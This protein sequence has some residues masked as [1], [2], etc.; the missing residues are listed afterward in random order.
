MLDVVLLFTGR[1]GTEPALSRLA[2]GVCV[3]GRVVTVTGTPIAKI[4]GDPES[5][6]QLFW[7]RCTTKYHRETFTR[8]V[9]RSRLP[10][11]SIR[12][13][14]FRQRDRAFPA[15]R[16]AVRGGAFGS[17]A[18]RFAIHSEE[19]RQ[20]SLLPSIFTKCKYTS[21]KTKM[22]KNKSSQMKLELHETNDINKSISAGL[23]VQK[24]ANI[25][26][27]KIILTTLKTSWNEQKEQV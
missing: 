20:I 9:R 24:K 22:T 4:H 17:S 16:S 27:K 6:Q 5:D 14:V 3:L 13:N 23:P 15:L 2:A 12:R 26:D 21:H 19:K 8:G 1:V 11:G 7:G 18:L 10:P 25:N